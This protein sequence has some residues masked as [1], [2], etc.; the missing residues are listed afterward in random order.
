MAITSNSGFP[1]IVH[2]GQFIFDDVDFSSDAAG[3]ALSYTYGDPLPIENTNN[4]LF[5]DEDILAEHIPTTI[6][7]PLPDGFVA[8]SPPTGIPTGGPDGSPMFTSI[9]QHSP[10][11]GPVVL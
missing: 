3:T 6:P 2:S 7:F 4:G 1:K 8:E 9:T 10:D 11:V 5:E